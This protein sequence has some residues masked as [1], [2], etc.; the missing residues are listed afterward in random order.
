MKRIKLTR[1]RKEDL[2]EKHGRDWKQ[3][4]KGKK[5]AKELKR[6]EIETRGGL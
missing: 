2:S 4:L 6:I 5:L 3:R 1:K